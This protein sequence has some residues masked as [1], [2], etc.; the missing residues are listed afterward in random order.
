MAELLAPAGNEQAFLA[1]IKSGAD[2]IY[3]GGEKYSARAYAG[4]FDEEALLWAIDVAHLYHKK[5]YLT[6]NTLVKER[7]LSELVSYLLP[8]YQAGLNGVIVQDF[9]VLLTLKEAFPD[10]ELHASTQM[11]ITGSLGAK[12]L[13]EQGVVRIVP[14]RELSLA[15]I[16]QIKQ[17]TGLE[18]ETFVHGAMC[19]GYSGQCLF[20]SMLGS[21][22]GNRGRC[23][24]P[25]RLPYKAYYK[26][27]QLNDASSMYQ[28]SLKDLCSLDILPDL[29]EAGIDSFKI[30]GRMKSKEY[31]SFVTGL[32]RYYMDAY[33]SEPAHYQVSEQDKRNLQA[34]FS[35]GSLQTG[36]Y[37]L[38]NGK[39]LVTLQKPG[40]Q[41]FLGETETSLFA[42]APENVSSGVIDFSVQREL[43]L[44]ESLEPEPIP[45]TGYFVAELDKPMSLTVLTPEHDF[46][47]VC[48]EAVC[49]SQKHPATKEEVRKA[50]LKTGNT[51]Y[52]FDKLE[53]TLDQGIFLPNRQL[54]EL[55]RR[56]LDELKEASLHA[57]RRKWEKRGKEP[58]PTGQPLKIGDRDIRKDKKITFTVLVQSITQLLGLNLS[59]SVKRIALS[60]DCLEE[61]TEK[62][63]I[64]KRRMYELQ[65]NDIQVV[66][67]FPPVTR[68]QTVLLYEKYRTL[69]RELSFDAFLVNNLET[70]GYVRKHFP[71]GKVI[72]DNRFYIFQG[73]TLEFF[74]AYGCREHFLSWELHE[75]EMRE[76]AGKAVSGGH[77]VSASVYGHIP[78][79]ESA[80][81]I[82]KTNDACDKGTKESV[83]LVD[84]Q[85]K[86]LPVF[87]HCSRCENTI[88][89]PVPLSLHKELHCLCE[90]GITDFV[91]S[92]TV[93]SVKKMNEILGWYERLVR[94]QKVSPMI[95]DFTKG[96]FAKG[97]E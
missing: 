1:A 28:L 12:L 6:V 55:R 81:C 70:L 43:H 74:E 10:M 30:E 64:C 37:F 79:M 18:I 8:F 39:Q 78:L 15:E 50:L 53:I 68:A 69:I 56:A 57:F 94:G 72:T 25:C 85:N 44:T 38:H 60:F 3:V 87:L 24:G 40:Y 14:A 65:E 91:F 96:H 95:S 84:R 29:M 52:A 9:G 63:D 77:T 41:S 88:Y 51:V 5:I 97:V 20:S 71:D 61:F 83:I 80:G 27:K 19:Y 62:I 42:N 73:K 66:L 31:V 13:K 36:Y 33:E 23:A 58:A 45:V 93:E 49:A 48:G 86:K 7:E 16:K 75:K 35:R 34:M 21:R 92:F 76:L 32:Y 11:T 54:N 59:D 90:M 26:G 89:N 82:L 2:A 4:N 22:S 67:Q 47:T 46:V 17:D